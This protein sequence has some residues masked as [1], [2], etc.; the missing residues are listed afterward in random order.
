MTLFESCCERAV[1]AAGDG[2]MAPGEVRTIGAFGASSWGGE[3]L[4]IVNAPAVAVVAAWVGA[5]TGVGP[6]IALGNRWCDPSCAG[7][8]TAPT[9]GEGRATVIAWD[10]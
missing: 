3:R 5:D 7:F 8:P 6:S 2:V 9:W 10:P 1:D 4:A